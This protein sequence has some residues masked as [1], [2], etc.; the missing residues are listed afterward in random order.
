MLPMSKHVLACQQALSGAESEMFSP[1]PTRNLRTGDEAESRI[2][3]QA[4][5]LLA[6][7]STRVTFE[8][9]A[10]TEDAV[11][12]RPGGNAPRS[13]D[14]VLLKL[15]KLVTFMYSPLSLLMYSPTSSPGRAATSAR[16]VSSGSTP[17]VSVTVAPA[18]AVTNNPPSQGRSQGPVVIPSG[19]DARW[20]VSV[21]P[22]SLRLVTFMYSANCP[23]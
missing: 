3:I 21:R 18:S 6:F 2:P 16:I 19:S 13:T 8:P 23:S 1:E 12:V 4:P 5:T 15:L 9:A 10:A 14:R 7:F 20:T 17:S 22:L 11:W